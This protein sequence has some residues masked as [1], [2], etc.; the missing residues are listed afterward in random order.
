MAPLGRKPSVR[1]KTV[2]NDSSS[3]ALVGMTRMK[4]GWG[5]GQPSSSSHLTK[6][7]RRDPPELT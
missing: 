1:L 3:L 7:G 2:L 5:V 4:E 6:Q